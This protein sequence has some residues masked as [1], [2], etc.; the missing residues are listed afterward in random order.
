[1]TLDGWARAPVGRGC[2][3]C[4]PGPAEP[5]LLPRHASPA[6]GTVG[7]YL[8]LTGWTAQRAAELST[9]EEGEAET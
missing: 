9:G 2:Q 6:G 5:Q 8:I 7:R 3:L 4:A 1:M